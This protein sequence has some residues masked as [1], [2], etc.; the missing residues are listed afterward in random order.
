M[1]ETIYRALVEAGLEGAFSPQDFLNF[2]CLGN[3]EV[4]GFESS[5]LESPST[6]NTPQVIHTMS[7]NPF[8]GS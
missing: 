8:F 2:F 7:Q 3:R 4:D 1:Y 5:G 6:T